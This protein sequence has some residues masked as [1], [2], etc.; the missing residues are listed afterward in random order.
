MG[1]NNKTVLKSNFS[2]NLTVKE[3]PLQLAHEIVYNA[4][5]VT[6]EMALSILAAFTDGE[7]TRFFK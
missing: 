6:D 7:L 1:Q 5:T 2:E 4:E 3:L